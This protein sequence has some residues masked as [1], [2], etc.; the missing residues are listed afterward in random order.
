MFGWLL[1]VYDEVLQVNTTCIKIPF[2]KTAIWIDVTK[3]KVLEY[4]FK[5]LLKVKRGKLCKLETI[6]KSIS[7]T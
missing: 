7:M 6:V 5:S 1:Y 4:N 3:V 2:I